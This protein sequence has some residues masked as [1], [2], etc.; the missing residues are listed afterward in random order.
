LDW[1]EAGEMQNFEQSAIRGGRVT[2]EGT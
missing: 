1:W 2:W